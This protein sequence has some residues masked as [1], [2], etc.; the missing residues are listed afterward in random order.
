[1]R[2]IYTDQSIDSLEEAIQ[3]LL[4][5]QGVPLTKVV[6]IRKI[7]LDKVDSLISNPDLGQYEEYLAHLDKGHRRLVEGNFKIIY[8]VENDCIFITDFFDTRQNPE[9]MKK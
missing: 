6:Q 1:M 4:K 5:V 2:I 7:L 9:K 8:R 3:F